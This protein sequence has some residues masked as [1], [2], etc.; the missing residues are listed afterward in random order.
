M[1]HFAYCSSIFIII[2]ISNSIVFS[3][4]IESV[5]R[6]W[7]SG[8]NML[9]LQQVIEKRIISFYWVETCSV[10]KN[11]QQVTVDVKYYNALNMWWKRYTVKRKK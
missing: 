2:I 5:L 10:F 11:K 7:L 6:F 3:V 1:N 9:H 4:K 8:W